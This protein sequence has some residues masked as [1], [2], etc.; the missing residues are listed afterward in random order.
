MKE[1]GIAFVGCTVNDDDINEAALA[2]AAPVLH[3]LIRLCIL[4]SRIEF[5]TLSVNF[6]SNSC[7]VNRRVMILVSTCTDYLLM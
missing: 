2:H 6:C 7:I 3:V 1:E 4:H 5:E